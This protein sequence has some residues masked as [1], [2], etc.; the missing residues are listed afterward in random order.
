MT[1]ALERRN[2]H[3]TISTDSGRP[4]NKGYDTGISKLNLSTESSS[5]WVMRAQPGETAESTRI[6]TIESGQ[7]R[8][9]DLSRI[10][11]EVK[12]ILDFRIQEDFSGM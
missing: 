7:V 12:I 3:Q 8:T 9:L 11:I 2:V 10:M 6:I 5:F 4:N 1:L